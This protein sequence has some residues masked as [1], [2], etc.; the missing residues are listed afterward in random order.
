VPKNAGVDSEEGFDL[1]TMHT[2]MRHM[3]MP[4][5]AAPAVHIA[6]SSHPSSC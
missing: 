2:L 4:H 3:G 6:V 1:S 5:L